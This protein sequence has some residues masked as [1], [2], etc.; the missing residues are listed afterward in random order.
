MEGKGWSRQE[1]DD[2]SRA[3]QMATGVVRPRRKAS[4][5]CV[6]V[7]CFA[8][9]PWKIPRQHQHD[10]G[11]ENPLSLLAEY[12]VYIVFLADLHSALK[13]VCVYVYQ[14]SMR[15]SFNSNGIFLIRDH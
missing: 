10:R 11:N 1:D 9:L 6:S 13:C 4:F 5:S 12:D 15:S 3:P 7:D 2:E 14:K 8:N